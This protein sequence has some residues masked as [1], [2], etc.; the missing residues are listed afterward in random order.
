[1][2][3]HVFSIVLLIVITP[4]INA[5]AGDW[6]EHLITH[7]V[8][9]S[10]TSLAA[11]VQHM[12]SP[13]QVTSAVVAAGTLV[14]DEFATLAQK[15]GS[16]DA[17]MVLNAAI[18]LAAYEGC[19]TVYQYCTRPHTLFSDKHTEGVMT[20]EIVEQQ[21]K[22]SQRGLATAHDLFVAK[23]MINSVVNAIGQRQEETD[24]QLKVVSQEFKDAEARINQKMQDSDKVLAERLSDYEGKVLKNTKNIAELSKIQSNHGLRIVNLEY[25]MNGNGQTS[26][27]VTRWETLHH[28]AA[29]LEAAVRQQAALLGAHTGNIQTLAEHAAELGN[30]VR[31]L[32]THAHDHKPGDTTII[33]LDDKNIGNNRKMGIMAK[34]GSMFSHQD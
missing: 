19:K 3:K 20:R 5:A 8:V 15:S 12:P 30:Q 13:D 22:D 32:N 28:K 11:L 16:M 7:H 27:I 31:E 24:K 1:M 33:P 21:I 2:V 10:Q 23:D 26:G 17:K 34:I 18:V 9:P 6:L 4:T 14:E 25:T 29:V